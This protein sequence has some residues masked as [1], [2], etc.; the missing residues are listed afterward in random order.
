MDIL[1]QIGVNNTVFIQFALFILAITFLS[2]FVFKGYTDS[3][4]ARKQN[5]KGGEELALEVQK[6]T[7]EL[8]SKYE[9]KLRSLNEQLK[10][11]ID[12][13]KLAATKEYDE[14]ISKARAE[15]NTIVLDNRTK[16]EKAIQSAH[17]EIK[18]QSSQVAMIVVNKL[19]GK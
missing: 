5:T 12:T 15:A 10:K 7:E 9:T 19:L 13:A 11:V 18:N 3:V 17:A 2:N 8:T 16:I 1:I 4:Y 6:K 14:Q